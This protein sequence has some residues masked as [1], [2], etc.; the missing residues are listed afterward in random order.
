M[1]LRRIVAEVA[2]ASAVW[3][4]M[5]AAA[6][7]RLKAITARTSQAAFAVNFP[8]GRCAS[9]EPLR[10][11]WTCS[12]I[13]CPRW[14]LS[15]AT[16]SRSRRGGGEERV[17]APGVEQ[18]VLPGGLLGIQVRDAAHDQA[19]GDLLAFFFEEN[20]VIGDLGDL[21]PG[22]PRPVASSRIARGTRSWSTRR[23]R[24]SRWPC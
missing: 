8:E 23:A 2:L 7:V 13:A 22:D 6:R 9:A 11:A 19:A 4:V 17:E 12:M 10:S 16:V 15:A 14:V 24:S 20:A 5:V 1:S 18:R 3:L 21:G